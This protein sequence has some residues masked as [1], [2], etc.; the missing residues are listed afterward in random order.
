M[1][2]DNDKNGAAVPTGCEARLWCFGGVATGRV[3]D[4]QLAAKLLAHRR[5][6]GVSLMANK[7]RARAAL[8]PLV[9]TYRYDQPLE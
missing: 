1:P 4:V 7:R 2:D 3:S 6:G 8:R 9:E 5:I